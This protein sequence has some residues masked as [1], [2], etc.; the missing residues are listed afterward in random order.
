MPPIA[1]RMRSSRASPNSTA[2]ARPSPAHGAS[3]SA[4]S[5][6]PSPAT[7][8]SMPWRAPRP[9]HAPDPGSVAAP[10]S[11]A[12]LPQSSLPRL[13]R[14]QSEES[15]LRQRF[16]RAPRRR[17]LKLTRN[18]PSR[19][20]ASGPSFSPTPISISPASASAIP[21]S[22][23]SPS[24]LPQAFTFSSRTIVAISGRRGTRATPH[25]L[26]LSFPPPQIPRGIGRNSPPPLKR[27]IQ[28]RPNGDGA[29]SGLPGHSTDAHKIKSG[30]NNFDSTNDV[31]SAFPACVWEEM[32]QN[33][34]DPR[35]LVTDSCLF[36][37]PVRGLERPIVEKRTAN[38]VSARHEAPVARVQAAVP[39]VAHH[40]IHAGRNHQVAVL[41]ITREAHGPR[42]CCPGH[43]G[44]RYCGEIVEKLVEVIRRGRLRKSHRLC[45]AIHKHNAAA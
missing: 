36:K 6:W 38:Y 23:S 7:P 39:V 45:D 30:S 19:S 29:I 43:P 1:T 33:V 5:I 37:L 15:R 3:P 11:Q 8:I 44:W 42:L 28:T 32:H 35:E 34:A 2:S 22:P 21:S 16:T 18:S 4:L 14:P 24:A 40:E 26:N 9:E 13:S 41:D 17:W 10:L 25:R 20:A 31:E 12:G 27:A